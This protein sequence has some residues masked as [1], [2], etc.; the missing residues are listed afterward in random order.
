MLR[1][2]VAAALVPARHTSY[3]SL[4]AAAGAAATGEPVAS[5]LGATAPSSASAAK[6]AAA[7]RRGSG[8]G[9]ATPARGAAGEG[10][11]GGGGGG[12]DGEALK[13]GVD[14]AYK[15]LKTLVQQD[16]EEY[17]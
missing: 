2:D 7:G 4:V 10:A 6:G 9:P 16:T 15:V 1:T 3:A 5:G 17:R 8:A 12:M 11:A 13:G 14:E